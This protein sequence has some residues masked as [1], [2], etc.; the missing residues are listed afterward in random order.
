MS[1]VPLPYYLKQQKWEA[2]WE[3]ANRALERLSGF[4][5]EGRVEDLL[6]DVNEHLRTAE[7]GLGKATG[8]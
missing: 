8:A 6:S 5:C 7:A 2:A 1:N 3:V 4:E